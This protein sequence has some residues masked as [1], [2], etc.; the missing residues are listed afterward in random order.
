MTFVIEESRT[1]QYSLNKI[2]SGSH[3][4]ARKRDAEYWHRLTQQALMAAGIPK[5]PTDGPWMVT[6]LYNDRLD[7]D[8]HGFITK[9]IVD[10]LKGWVIPDDTRKYLKSVTQGFWEGKGV[11][12]E[13]KEL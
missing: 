12:V 10:G 6:A 4:S 2:Y 3:W 7:A 5:H 8:N 9:C 13:V 1:G 11:L